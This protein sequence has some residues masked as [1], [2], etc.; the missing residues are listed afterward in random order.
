M[1]VKT[2]RVS[3]AKRPSAEQIQNS[4]RWEA[5]LIA[6]GTPFISLSNEWLT[7]FDEQSNIE[8]ASTELVRL[9]DIAILKDETK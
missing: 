7:F 1:S 3:V 9:I 5:F 4:I 8:T 2:K 6:S